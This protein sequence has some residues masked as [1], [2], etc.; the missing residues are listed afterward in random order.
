MIVL[1]TKKGKTALSAATWST[2]ARLCAL[3]KHEGCEM[4]PKRLS[5]WK[6]LKWR[7]G[8]RDRSARA[9]RELNEGGR[10]K[11]NPEGDVDDLCSMHKGLAHFSKLGGHFENHLAWFLFAEEENWKDQLFCGA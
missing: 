3:E 6:E 7:D 8:M 9:A 2:A 10:P 4:L 1:R 5:Q 11:R